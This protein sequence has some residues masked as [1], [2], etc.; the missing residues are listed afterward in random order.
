MWARGLVIAV[1]C[2]VACDAAFNICSTPL[3]KVAIGGDPYMMI[4]PSTKI[5]CGKAPYKDIKHLGLI[6]NISNSNSQLID[7]GIIIIIITPSKKIL[8]I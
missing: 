4:L 3:V 1:L 7:V 5:Q 2:E 6:I 8:L